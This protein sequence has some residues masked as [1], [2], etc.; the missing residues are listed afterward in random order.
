MAEENALAL[1]NPPVLGRARAMLDTP[2]TRRAAP[3]A[4]L[5]AIALASLL[6]WSVVSA[7]A[8]RTLFNGLGDSDKAAVAAALDSAGIGYTLDPASGALDVAGGDF[9]RARLLLA[10]QGLPKAAPDGAS[11]LDAMPLGASRALEGERLRSA[12]EMDLARTIEA[13]DAVETAKVHLAVEAPSLFVRDRAKSTASVLVTLAQGRS[14]SQ[15][16]VQAIVNLVGSSIVGLNADDVSVVDQAGRLLSIDMSDPLAAEAAR[17]FEVQSRIEARYRTAVSNLLGPMVGGDGFTV[18]VSADLNFDEK[19]ATRETY[20]E[21]D[22]AMRQERQQWTSNDGAPPP[23]VGIPGT[24]SNTP[25]PAAT[26]TATPPPATAPAGVTPGRTSQDTSR[27]FELGREV[28][29]S[30]TAAGQVRRL[31]VAVALKDGAKKRSAA[32]L[33]AIDGLVKAAVGFDGQRGDQVTVT[34][35]PFVDQT[36]PTPPWYEAEWLIPAGRNLGAVLAV[37]FFV[38]GI[39]RPMLKRR[40][41]AAEARRNEVH[42]LIEGE[43]A[44]A[45]A[46]PVT[47]DMIEATPSYAAR[48]ALVR[49]FVRANPDRAAAVV[50]NLVKEGADA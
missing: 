17:Q 47:L 43:L 27:T 25:P 13:I 34:S 36:A 46:Q 42:A 22:R 26:V 3:F 12:R 7:P 33:A 40:A 6:I 15:Q 21:S 50:R 19:Q 37:A 16:Q 24:L 28:S 39:A 35:R 8:S 32:E 44:L 41:A 49:D 30:K 38:F 2:L 11:T 1:R 31:S 45:P 9:H 5:A 29:V 18:Q 48:V 4:V 10:G 20:P 23:A 14:L